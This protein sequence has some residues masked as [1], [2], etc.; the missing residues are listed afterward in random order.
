MIYSAIWVMKKRD[1]YNDGD[2]RRRINL[3]L[4][5]DNARK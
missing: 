4:R 3:P 1:D 5:R 2:K